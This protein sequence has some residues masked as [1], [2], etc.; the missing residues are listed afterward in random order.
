M[1]HRAINYPLPRPPISLLAQRNWVLLRRT[2]DTTEARI[3]L[4]PLLMQL[5]YDIGAVNLGWQRGH[6][7]LE[8]VPGLVTDLAYI[9]P[10]RL[11]F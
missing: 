9:Q 1:R 5:G 7:G 6:H 3:C 10:G 11:R 4:T 2:F 8:L